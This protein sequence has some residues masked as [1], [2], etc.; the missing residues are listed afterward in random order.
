MGLESLGSRTE[1]QKGKKMEHLIG[2]F[3]RVLSG[4]EQLF[5]AMK[6]LMLS[7]EEAVQPTKP[8]SPYKYEHRTAYY[9]ER[10]DAGDSCLKELIDARS[11]HKELR[12]RDGYPIDKSYY[13]PLVE[14]I[15][16]LQAREP[17]TVEQL[18]MRIEAGELEREDILLGIRIREEA[19]ENGWKPA[20]KPVSAE[21]AELANYREVLA[22]LS[23]PQV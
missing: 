2:R 9:I 15:E 19:K 1:V 20:Q 5:E 22:Q 11:R 10:V 4:F 12:A 3:E 23:Q 17:V 6:A 8:K 14:A 21:E 18:I 13:N 16:V 7:D